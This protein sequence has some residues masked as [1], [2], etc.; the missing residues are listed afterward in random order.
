MSAR[1]PSRLDR[2]ALLIGAGGLLV[3]GCSDGAV[4]SSGTSTPTASPTTTSAS[5]TVTASPTPTGP[6]IHQQDAGTV[7]TRED[8]NALVDRLGRAVRSADVDAMRE[9]VPSVNR[10]VWKRRLDNIARF[11]MS[12]LGFAFDDTYDRQTNAAGGRLEMDANVAFLHQ[13]TGVDARPAVQIYRTTLLKESPTAPVR[14]L[15]LKGPDDETSPAPWDLGD[16]RVFESRH[17]VVAALPVD[18]DRVRAAMPVIDRAVAR[19][20]AVIPPPPGM[21]RAYFAVGEAGSRLYG[22]VS[23]N[24]SI[25]EAS[26]YALRI[27]YVAPAEAARQGK[28]GAGKVYAGG[29]LM[30]NP[31]AFVSTE[32]LEQ[33]ACHETLHAL[34]YQWGSSDPWPTE[35]LAEWGEQGTLR[36]LLA[37]GSWRSTVR[38]GFAGFAD[39]MAGVGALDYQVFHSDATEYTNYECAAAVYAYLES[40]GGRR[41][42]LR[43]GRLMFSNAAD[44]AIR[45][46]GDVDQATLFGKVQRWVATL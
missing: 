16:W 7:I 37:S 28:I 30:L 1:L 38:A 35:G 34:S 19:A 22:T 45:Q 42:A 44:E 15:S 17:A 43:F 39:R 9:I 5:P 21:S 40:R 27:G 13:I 14:V 26:G 31:S 6:I 10:K 20:M 24:E 41:E 33:V 11:P 36:G 29:R 32:R 46:M 8:I 12:D 25:Q 3:A 23:S 2:R 18:V 4:E